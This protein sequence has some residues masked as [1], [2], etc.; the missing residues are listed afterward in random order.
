MVFIYLDGQIENTYGEWIFKIGEKFTP[1]SLGLEIKCKLPKMWIL[2][3]R[4]TSK[5]VHLQMVHEFNANGYVY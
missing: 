3:C 2:D 4:S 5:F 1:D